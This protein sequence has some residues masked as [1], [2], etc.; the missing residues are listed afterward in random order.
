MS[1]FALRQG[2]EVCRVVTSRPLVYG[3]TLSSDTLCNFLK[4]TVIA[5][6]GSVYPTDLQ[7]VRSA[8]RR[9]R[10]GGIGFC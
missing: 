9:H 4:G 5:V 3:V 7:Q 10:L 6:R 8:G 1:V 2:K